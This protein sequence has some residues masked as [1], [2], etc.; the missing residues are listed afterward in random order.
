MK[1]ENEEIKNAIRDANPPVFPNLDEVHAS[2]R[3]KA[4]ANVAHT[5]RQQGPWLVCI[6]C[7]NSHTISWIG[8]DKKLVGLDENGGPI[9]E[10]R[11]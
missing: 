9:L 2:L 1:D 3:A 10:K 5:P 4:K 7:Q 6:S 8:V 11:F